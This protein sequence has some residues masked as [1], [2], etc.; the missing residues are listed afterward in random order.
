MSYVKI[1]Q[2]MTAVR[3]WSVRV[4]EVGPLVSSGVDRRLIGCSKTRFGKLVDDG[5]LRLYKD[6][7]GLS[8]R[9]GMVPLE[10]VLAAPIPGLRGKKALFGFDRKNVSRTVRVSNPRRP[11]DLD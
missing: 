5:R 11:K 1:H 4:R 10:D 7:P 2:R 8:E 9:V 3:L 6:L